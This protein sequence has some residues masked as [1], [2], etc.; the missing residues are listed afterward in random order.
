MQ[1]SGR[2]YANLAG[3]SRREAAAGERGVLGG[4]LSGVR[5]VLRSRCCEFGR[6]CTHGAAAHRARGRHAALR[7]RKA[8]ARPG[9]LRRSWR[10]RGLGHP[11][12]RRS[13]RLL[14]HR[15]GVGG[16][17]K[18]LGACG[19]P[20]F[21]KGREPL[22]RDRDEWRVGQTPTAGSVTVPGCALGTGL[23]SGDGRWGA[24]PGRS[25]GGSVTAWS[26]AGVGQ[27]GAEERLC[28]RRR[29]VRPQAARARGAPGRCSQPW[30]WGLD[31]VIPVGLC[32][33][34]W[35]SCI[36]HRGKASHRHQPPGVQCQNLVLR[37][38]A[39]PGS[40]P[41]DCSSAWF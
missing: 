40:A 16:T 9:P 31:S 12:A 29:W 22:G 20:G 3:L 30:R 21:L 7:G 37:H 2:G 8:P 24:A 28:P 19:A 39:L 34:L 10:P 35:C 32:Q 6:C 17:R 5:S 26:C 4:G 33:L 27:A 11:R 23:Q 1:I 13:R 15:R 36:G 38:T 41:E 14:Q 25:P 18:G